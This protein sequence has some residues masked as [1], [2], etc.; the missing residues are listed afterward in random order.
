MEKQLAIIRGVG[1][2][3][4]DCHVPTLWFSVHWDECLGALQC[5]QGQQLIDLVKVAGFYDIQRLE[6]QPCWILVEGNLVTFVGL[7]KIGSE[8]AAP[9]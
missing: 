9:A 2:G 3:M 8:V 4:R 6:G 1:F 7:A 5:F